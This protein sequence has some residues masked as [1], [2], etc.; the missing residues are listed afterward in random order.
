VVDHFNSLD[1]RTFHQR[2]WENQRWWKV[3]TQAEAY[4][5]AFRTHALF[6]L[7]LLCRAV[8]A[9]WCVDVLTHTRV[10]W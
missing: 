10:R 1:A 6:L 3:P 9:P 4:P 7:L 5:L 8:G 2:Y